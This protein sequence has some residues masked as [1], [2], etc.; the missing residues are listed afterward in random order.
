M[1]SYGPSI[2]REGLV[3]SLD[4]ANPRGFFGEP[5]VNLEA[6]PI[7]FS[8]WTSGGTTQVTASYG[9]A[10]DGSNNGTRV[11]TTEFWGSI[12]PSPLNATAYTWS[13]YLK[14]KTGANQ[15]IN[16]YFEDNGDYGGTFVS[17]TFNVSGQWQRFSLTA[18]TAASNNTPRFSIRNGDLIAW[19]IQLEQKAHVTPFVVGT[20]GATVATGGGLYDLS[21]HA[22]HADM[23]YSPVYNSGNSG[24]LVF[25]GISNFTYVPS[26]F[27]E[28]NYLLA[29]AGYSW[30][31]TAWFKFPVSPTQLRDGTVNGGNCSYSIVG[32]GGGIGGAETFDMFVGG[33]VSYTNM[34]TAGIKGSKTYI[35]PSTV[36]D[37]VWHHAVITWDG[38]AMAGYTYFDGVFTNNLN[39]GGATLQGGINVSIGSQNNGASVHCFEGSIANVCIYNIS[40]ASSQVAQNYNATKRRFGK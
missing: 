27:P 40:L 16:C 5:T 19:G 2:V 33:A 36:N 1:N 35:S 12:I 39:I 24:Y 23:T 15:T 11:T 8:L 28:I 6:N 32:R 34:C 22:N 38:T 26:E 37:N 17:T 30:T 4:V 20:R 14:S 3:L 25:D 21:G 7:N 10:P 18:T 9:V 31:V 13:I 29:E